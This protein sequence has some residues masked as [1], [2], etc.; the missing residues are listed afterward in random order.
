MLEFTTKLI[1]VDLDKVYVSLHYNIFLVI[2]VFSIAFIDTFS[3]SMVC[4]DNFVDRKESIHFELSCGFDL[5]LYKDE[6]HIPTESSNAREKIN[7][8]W[9][10]RSSHLCLMF[11]KSCIRK[12]IKGFIPQCSKTK[13]FL[14]V[15]DKQFVHSDKAL[16]NTLMKRLSNM[17]FDYSKD[18]REHII[19]RRDT[20]A[21]LKSLEVEIFSHY[22][23]ISF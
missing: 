10:E 18:E 14:K 7:Y 2:I 4:G 9:W 6:L 19:E 3:I 15:I 20:F 12:S 11:I 22:W 8:E 13:D 1:L 16:A 23:F 17:L 21:Q 5:T